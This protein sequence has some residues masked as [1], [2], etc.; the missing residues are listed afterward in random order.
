MRIENIKKYVINLKSRPDRRDTC[1]QE[2]EYM[3][4]SDLQIFEAIDTGGYRGCALS[5]MKLAEMAK[6]MN[7]PYIC[8]L[9]DDMFFMPNAKN[10]LNHALQLLEQQDWHLLHL[11]PHFNRP[12][13][14]YNEHLID[15]TTLPEMDP[16]IHRGIH[17]THGF[18]YKST[19]YDLILDWPDDGMI[20]IDQHFSQNIYPHKQSFSYHLPIVSQRPS[21]SNINKSHDNNHYLLTYNW[22]LYTQNKLPNAHMSFK[23]CHDLRA[24]ND[25]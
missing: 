17:G 2:S 4:W 9:E 5:H 14:N 8:V 16:K 11:G 20:A 23:T 7:L 19:I 15:M 6:E 10:N 22:N 24:T 13:S 12:V 18:I 25:E 3:G 1:L 21:F